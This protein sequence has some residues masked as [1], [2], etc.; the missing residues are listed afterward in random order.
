MTKA[1][2]TLLEVAEDTALQL[3]CLVKSV[4]IL[5]SY[6]EATDHTGANRDDGQACYVIQR[7][8]ETLAEKLKAG[9][10][11]VYKSVRKAG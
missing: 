3:D 9:V 4:M 6:M 2:E 7:Y 5:E 8:L 10:N 1:Y 11:E